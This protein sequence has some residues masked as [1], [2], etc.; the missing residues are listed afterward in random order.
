MMSMRVQVCT[1]D[2]VSRHSNRLTLQCNMFNRKGLQNC[3]R[4]YLRFQK[5]LKEVWDAKQSS[6]VAVFPKCIIVL[7]KL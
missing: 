1:V 6:D 3:Q 2:A 4:P 5:N 7:S